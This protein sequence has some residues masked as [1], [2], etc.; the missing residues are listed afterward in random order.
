[1]PKDDLRHKLKAIRTGT[2]E[3]REGS[4]HCQKIGRSAGEVRSEQEE[5]DRSE[6]RRDRRVGGRKGRWKADEPHA[7]KR[8]ET[9]TQAG[10]ALLGGKWG[11]TYTHRRSRSRRFSWSPPP[12]LDSTQLSARVGG[13]GIVVRVVRRDS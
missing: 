6:D 8:G 5:R 2:G 9:E 12:A 11:V 7:G 4:V 1:M 3:E 10:Q 13:A